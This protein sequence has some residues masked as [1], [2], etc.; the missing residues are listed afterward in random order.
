MCTK[1]YELL[2]VFNDIINTLSG[3]YYPITNLFITENL[4]IIG[5]F[6]KCMTEELEW[7]QCIEIMK[8]KWLNYYQNI[9]IIYLHGIIF[10][11]RYKLN[12]LFDWETYSK[13]LVLIVD[14]YALVR[15]VR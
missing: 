12:Y 8:S 1:I 10:D 4:N 14:V 6:D 11:P 9:P 15:D 3:I 13:C 7:V 2:K 5:T